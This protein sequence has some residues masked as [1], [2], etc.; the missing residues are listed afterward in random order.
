M[1]K[2]DL[3]KYI[4]DLFHA[5]LYQGTSHQIK[6]CKGKVEVVEAFLTAYETKRWI[7][8]VEYEKLRKE[9]EDESI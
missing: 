2:R 3:T 8:T 6:D 9:K 7:P 5:C 1:K 4:E